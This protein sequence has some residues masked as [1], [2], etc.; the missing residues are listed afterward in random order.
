MPLLQSAPLGRHRFVL[1][2]GSV[3]VTRRAR[4][5]DLPAVR[6]LHTRCS[7]TSRYQRYL[8]AKPQ[9]RA[10]EWDHLA[11]PER[12]TTWV[13]AE[14][15]T[16]SQLIAMT[17]VVVHLDQSDLHDL[18]LLVVDPWQR[19]GLGTDLAHYAA[20]HAQAMGGRYLT[21][22]THATHRAMQKVLHRMGAMPWHI[23]GAQAEIR[24][25][26]QIGTNPAW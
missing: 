15:E 21:A 19:R 24:V 6:D 16:P 12:A 7:D 18:G 2:D 11:D 26:L 3:A 9:L 20:A 10:A 14:A 25:P 23:V 13:T 4:M 17:N 22:T 8:V 1:A 5:E